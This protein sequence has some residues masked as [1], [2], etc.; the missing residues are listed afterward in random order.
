MN[1]LALSMIVPFAASF[2]AW[3]VPA[4]RKAIVSAWALGFTALSCIA[5]CYAV[6]QGSTP[7]YFR[8]VNPW[9]NISFAAD[10]LAAVMACISSVVGFVI[11]LYSLEYMKEYEERG[12][13]YTWMLLFIGSMMGL[14]FSSNLILLFCFWEMTSVCS[15]RLIGFYRTEKDLKAAQKAFLV[16]FLGSSLLLAGIILV[17]LSYGST[18]ADILQGKSLTLLVSFLFLAGIVSKSAQLPFQTWL[19]DAGVAPT[20]VTALLHAAVLVKI[21]VYV[22]ARVFGVI[23]SAPDAFYQAVIVLSSVTILVSAGCALVES[24][25]KR[26]LAYSTVS[27]LGYI[28]LVLALQTPVSFAVALVYIAA[29]SIAKAG[30]FLCAGIIE[31]KAGTKNIYELGGLGKVMPLTSAAFILCAFSVIGIPPFFG[32]WP[33]FMTVLLSAQGSHMFAAAAACVGA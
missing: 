18:E 21:G 17:Y 26:I 32:F 16:T 4:R 3:V 30:L 14:V 28:L 11:G 7:S 20:P 25:I 15:W 33:K 22:F 23:F 31:H 9:F 12:T 29:H 19:P 13:F 27:Q 10:G 2:L 6:A 5:V 1:A 24:N 8:G